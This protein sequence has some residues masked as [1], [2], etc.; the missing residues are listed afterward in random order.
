MKQL[1]YWLV[2]MLRPGRQQE[3]ERRWIEKERY[4]LEKEAILEN[5]RQ[6]KIQAEQA[7]RTV[8]KITR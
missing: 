7:A 5:A 4:L 8:S 6:R 1:V 3:A 2:K